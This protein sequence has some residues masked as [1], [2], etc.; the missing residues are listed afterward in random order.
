M[1][2]E[3]LVHY[4][5]HNKKIAEISSILCTLSYYSAK[6]LENRRIKIENSKNI[7]ILKNSTLKYVVYYQLLQNVF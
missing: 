4:L 2:W 7:Y 3:L 5:V 1:E 6:I